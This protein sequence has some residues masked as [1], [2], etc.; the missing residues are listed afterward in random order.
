MDPMSNSSSSLRSGVRAGVRTGAAAAGLGAWGAEAATGGSADSG[1]A[2][3]LGSSL[4]IISTWGG[5]RRGAIGW[6][7]AAPGGTGR[8]DADEGGWLPVPAISTGG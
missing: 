6:G 2:A 8:E 1:G 7:L 3:G 5:L 4:R